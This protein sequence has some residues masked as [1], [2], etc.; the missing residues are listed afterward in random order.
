MLNSLKSK[1]DSIQKE[2]SDPE[3]KNGLT[4]DVQVTF[5]KYLRMYAAE[6]KTYKRQ[7]R[8]FLMDEKVELATFKTKW[9][10][11]LTEE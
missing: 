3:R 9:A 7:K 8:D 2:R 5:D 10:E 1:V 6:S 11:Y 4:R